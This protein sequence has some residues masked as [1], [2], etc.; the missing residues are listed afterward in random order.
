MNINNITSSLLEKIEKANKDFHLFDGAKKILVGL[1]GGAD[2]TCL[3][4]ALKELSEEYGFTLYALHV[5]HMIRGEE[6]DK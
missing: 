6:A 2:S 1:S 3:V 5:N 4:T